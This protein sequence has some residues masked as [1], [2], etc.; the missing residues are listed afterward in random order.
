MS[1]RTG[2]APAPT[3]GRRDGMEPIDC[4]TV[5][6]DLV[7]AGGSP[8]FGRTWSSGGLEPTTYPWLALSPPQCRCCGLAPSVGL[9]PL[10][11]FLPA[12]LAPPVLPCPGSFRFGFFGAFARCS[13]LRRVWSRVPVRLGSADSGCLLFAGRCP[14]RGAWVVPGLTPVLRVPQCSQYHRRSLHAWGARSL[15]HAWGLGLRGN[16]HV[17]R[18][19]HSLVSGVY[20]SR[21]GRITGP[22]ESITLVWHTRTRSCFW[23]N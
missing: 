2:L 13:G 22:C 17:S 23:L 21:P 3:V 18:L 1:W 20:P 12:R 5:L 16:L 11:F 6:G 14:G 7:L 15:P 10:F 9:P 4:R 8:R 19:L